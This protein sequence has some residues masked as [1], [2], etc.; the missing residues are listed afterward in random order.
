MTIDRKLNFKRLFG[1]LNILSV[2]IDLKFSI[3]SINYL[4][5]LIIDISNNTELNEEEVFYRVF[6]KAFDIQYTTEQGWYNVDDY[7]IIAPD[8]WTLATITLII[9]L[10]KLAPGFNNLDTLIHDLQIETK[11]PVLRLNLNLIY[12]IGNLMKIPFLLIR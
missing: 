11:N 12:I 4:S 8:D 9:N 10:N 7:E 6:S 1:F 5:D 3:T 2:K